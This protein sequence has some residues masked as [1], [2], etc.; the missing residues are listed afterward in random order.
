MP[1]FTRTQYSSTSL[2]SVQQ[3]VLQCDISLEMDACRCD[4]DL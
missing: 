4:F 1:E 3:E 2:V